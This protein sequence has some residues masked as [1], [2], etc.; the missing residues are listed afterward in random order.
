MTRVGDTDE[1][2]VDCDG[3]SADSEGTRRRSQR[4]N[5]YSILRESSDPQERKKGLAR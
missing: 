2:V 3:V 1:V 5:F 4:M